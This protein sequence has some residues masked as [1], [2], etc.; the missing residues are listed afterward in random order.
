MFGSAESFSSFAEVRDCDHAR[1]DGEI[2]KKAARTRTSSLLGGLCLAG[3]AGLFAAPIFFNVP[4]VNE[5]RLS[6]LPQP[7]V[8]ATEAAMTVKSGVLCPFSAKSA[9]ASVDEIAVVTPPRSGTVIPQDHTGLIYRSNAGFHGEDSFS[10][11][12]HMRSPVLTGKSLVHFT[13]AVR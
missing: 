13:V 10:V 5:C 1:H 12:M 9:W 7:G 2:R 3:V 4:T 8:A 11:E 6:P